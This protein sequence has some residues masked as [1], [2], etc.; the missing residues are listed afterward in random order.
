M[1][2]CRTS[3]TARSAKASGLCRS[4][5]I[6]RQRRDSFTQAAAVEALLVRHAW[7]HIRPRRAARVRWTTRRRCWPQTITVAIE[8]AG[9]TNCACRQEQRQDK[10]SS[11]TQISPE[12]HPLNPIDRCIASKLELPLE[13]R[14]LSGWGRSIQNGPVCRDD[15]NNQ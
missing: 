8:T 1:R 10:L 5:K 2:F 6:S 7:R 9:D 11:H 4:A 13:K 3:P 14:C 15:R 12:V